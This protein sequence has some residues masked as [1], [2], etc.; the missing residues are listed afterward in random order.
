M[1]APVELVRELLAYRDMNIVSARD[2]GMITGLLAGGSI[3]FPVLT[4]FAVGSLVAAA[5]QRVRRLRA[6]KAVTGIEVP[7]PAIAMGATAVAGIARKLRMCISSLHGDDVLVEHAVIRDRDGVVLRRTESAPF[8][9]EREGQPP[10]MIVGAMRRIGLCSG[11]FVDVERGD[12][13]LARMGIPR[14]FAISGSLQIAA[15][16][17]ATK[18]SVLGVLEDEIV[19]EAAFHRD[20]GQ[21]P[22]MRGRPGMPLLVSY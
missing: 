1:V 15:I 13:V 8:W 2:W 7:P 18:V 3:A 9:L 20:G 19:A 16:A 17:E 6:K 22:V 4:P 5:V 12:A 10:V 11:S 21:V 14:D